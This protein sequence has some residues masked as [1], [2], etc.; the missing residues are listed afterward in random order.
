MANEEDGNAFSK[1]GALT[2]ISSSSSSGGLIAA[3]GMSREGSLSSVAG[4]NGDADCHLIR[5]S[6]SADCVDSNSGGGT[7][8][9]RVKFKGT[10]AAPDVAAWDGQWHSLD[11]LGGGD[12]ESEASTG[13]AIVGGP[14]LK[15][16]KP[17]ASGDT[18]PQL[19]AVDDSL[20]PAPHPNHGTV[21]SRLLAAAAPKPMVRIAAVSERPRDL[22]SL[23]AD[24]NLT[25]YMTVF[26]EQDVDLQVFL[27]LTDNDL[28][29]IGIK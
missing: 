28:Q 27:T 25:K 22:A 7:T 21:S 18:D 1:T 19:K 8:R 29:E 2:I 4:G 9:S 15:N 3:L 6:A 24:L 10:D 5:R 17:F 20:P 23:L 13:R 16:G 11:T 26:D 14:R 12:H